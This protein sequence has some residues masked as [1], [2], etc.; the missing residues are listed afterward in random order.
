MS[1]VEAREL[2]TSPP[3][4]LVGDNTGS[5]TGMIPAIGTGFVWGP[6]TAGK[7][8]AFGI[9][10]GLAIANGTSFMGY[11]T[12]KGK[13]VYCVGEG[14][15]DLGLRKQARLAREERDRTVA[16]AAIAEREGDE[17][18][19]A[20]AASL[21]PYTDDNLYIVTEPFTVPLRNPS[22]EQ[23]DSLRKAITAITRLNTP[24]PD[25]DPDTFDYVQL[26]ILDSLANFTGRSISNDSSANLLV[27]GMQAMSRELEC[28]I[29]AIAH[30]TEK[31]D[32]MLGAG[33]LLN[34]ADTEIEVRPDDVQTPGALRTASILSHKAK[35]SALF[36]QVGYRVEPC[37]WTQ[38]V[39]DDDGN[40][41]G[42]TVQV[43]SAT[44]RM[45]ETGKSASGGTTQA[46]APPAPPLPEIRD[47][48]RP[49]RKRS[50]LKPQHRHGLTVVP[51]TTAPAGARP[52]ASLSAEADTR[53]DLVAAVLERRCPVCH[54]PQSLGCDVRMSPAPWSLG[55]GL[56]GPVFAHE[57]RVMA[58]VE[59]A[60]DP[61][62]FLTAALAAFAAA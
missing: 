9:D 60:P 26:V 18:A 33:R 38:A 16:I 46:A 28:F 24:G 61:E 36:E 10:L 22:Q 12:A 52:L 20:Y 31:G 32:K 25:D 50:G 13:V 53:R 6:R 30:P 5:T 59:A 43:R 42:E 58:A 23:T 40:P 4:W 8:L 21:P 15:Y 39:E 7:S 29:L 14:L 34:S 56:K 37:E 54:R 62:K 51:A 3:E 19:R 48:E 47:V 1:L 55:R 17:A 27:S 41:T 2:D 49:H 45:L 57:D 44:I 35:Y 11:P